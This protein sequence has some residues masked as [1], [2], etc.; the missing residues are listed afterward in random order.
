LRE[1]FDNGDSGSDEGH[2]LN[3]ITEIAAS[4]E[5]LAEQLL[6]RWHGSREE[7]LRVLFD[8]CG[9]ADS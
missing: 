8:H 4:G 2:F 1:Q 5:T 7:K 6:S 9:Y 3:S